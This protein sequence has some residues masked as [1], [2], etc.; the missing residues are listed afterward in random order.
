MSSDPHTLATTT[1]K[2]VW[3]LV[4]VAAGAAEVL[5]PLPFVNGVTRL[6]LRPF[7]SGIYAV[8]RL[9]CHYLDWVVFIATPVYCVVLL[10][11]VSV[12]CW[13]NQRGRLEWCVVKLHIC[14]EK[15]SDEC[16]R[17]GRPSVNVLWVCFDVL[18]CFDKCY[19]CS[20][21]W[22]FTVLDETDV[23]NVWPCW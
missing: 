5:A 2:R 11:L 12:C 1:E 6:W 20:L 21:G 15:L 23:V 7:P 18:V 8:R 3:N 17:L 13:P 14:W 22:S 16:V 4:G 19:E 9:H 10:V